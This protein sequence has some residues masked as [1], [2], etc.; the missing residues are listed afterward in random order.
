MDLLTTNPSLV[1]I[2]NKVERV[3]SFVS[4]SLTEAEQKYSTYEKECLAIV[5]ACELWYTLY[6]YGRKFEVVT[7]NQALTWLFGSSHKTPISSRIAKWTIRMQD[8][9]FSATHRKGT[10]H[11]NADGLSRNP[12]TSTA[13][14]GE[15]PT[16]PLYGTPPPMACTAHRDTG[17][18]G[19]KVN[20]SAFQAKQEYHAACMDFRLRG[21]DSSSAYF[22][23]IDKEAETKEDW[24]ALQEEDKHCSH[25]IALLAA[26]DTTSARVRKVT[27]VYTMVDGLLH[28]KPD[29]IPRKQPTPIPQKM[30][31]SETPSCILCTRP[32]RQMRHVVRTTPRVVVPTS[33]KA[34]ILHQHHGLPIAGHDGRKRV[35][36]TL[37][38]RYHWDGMHDDTKRWIQACTTCARRKTPR[39]QRTGDP[40]TMLPRSPGV[41]SLDIQGPLP[42]T[43]DGN[44]Y[45]LTM[46]DCF[47][48]WGIAV[49]IPDT[50]APTISNSIFKRLLCVHGRPR[51]ILTDRGKELI[52]KAV[53]HLCKRWK[54]MKI[55]T[56]GEQPQAN[57]VERFHRY[58][59]TSMTALHGSF[60]L[61]WDQYVDAATFTYLVSYSEATGYSPFFLTYGHEAVKPQEIFLGRGPHVE[62]ESE[63]A[64]STHTCTVLAEAYKQA[65]EEQ[66]AKAH[67]NLEYRKKFMRQVDFIPGQKVLYW[68]TGASAKQQIEESRTDNPTPPVAE[69]D[70]AADKPAITLPAKWKYNW[71]GPHT[72]IG[73]S[74]TTA[75]TD[76]NTNFI[77]NCYDVLH[78]KD[79]RIVRVNVNRLTKLRPWNN[80]ITST[81]PHSISK[82]SYKTI[83]LPEVGSLFIAPF[84]EVQDDDRQGPQHHRRWKNHVP[85]AM[86]HEAEHATT[87]AL[88]VDRHNDWTHHMDTAQF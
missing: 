17:L 23:T 10:Q 64:Y 59:N 36:A 45:I 28:R 32:Q 51:K 66:A 52:G 26:T 61:D 79:G 73:K 41:W 43:T 65:Y 58:L 57:P 68:Q 13:P 44:R 37:S 29:K 55:E 14:Y 53:Q 75:I 24:K 30:D 46:M 50:T 21:Q 18:P 40:Q 15:R 39:P 27:Q 12:L 31:E 33:L 9:D 25:L 80:N 38:E 3:V 62:F 81:A 77:P 60:G 78:C 70:A 4:R 34:Y 2:K 54:I 22:G 1:Q 87:D 19:T 7:D 47:T 84:H 20:L 72:I 69:R 6:L 11:C 8:L 48:R 67:H 88:G 42:V 35:Y 82:E 49:A 74:T 83:G 56:T 71:T 86:E 16:E 63:K 76:N 5:W 85:V